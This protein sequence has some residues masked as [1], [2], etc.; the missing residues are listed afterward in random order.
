MSPEIALA[1]LIAGLMG[2]A[3][4]V[5][6]C[7]GL[8]G[9]FA[10]HTA[11]R[12]TRHSLVRALTYNTGRLLSYG[13]LGAAVAGLGGGLVAEAPALAMPMRIAAGVL[14]ILMGLQ[15]AFGIQLLK[16]VERFGGSVWKHIAP[17]A[18]RLLPLDTATKS[19]G[20]GL[21]WGLLPCGLVYSM[22]AVALASGNPV[23]GAAAMLAFGIGTTPAMLL[24]GMSAYRVSSFIRNK[25]VA[26]GGLMVAIGILTLAMPAWH[27]L[28]PADDGH[29]HHHGHHH[30]QST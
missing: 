8:S 23:N 29:A 13:V 26:A 16:P 12:S 25:R 5:G 20:L 22:L 30:A 15:I 2:S 21:L 27:A 10:T 7:G 6:M 17:M 11:A 14:V 1:A 3:H 9:L 4:C 24:T 19:L 18:N 28:A